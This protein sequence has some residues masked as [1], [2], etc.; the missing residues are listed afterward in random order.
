MLNVEEAVQLIKEHLPDW[1]VVESSIDGLSFGETI[2]DLQADRAYPPFNRVMMDGIAV[3][4]ADYE[5][6]L[7]EFRVQGVVAAGTPMVE[8]KGVGN[9]F[10]VMTGAPLPRGA[11]LVIQYEHLSIKDGLALLTTDIPRSYFENIHLQGSDCREGEVM[12][13]GHQRLNGP[14]WGI[15]AS[16]GYATVKIKR[17]PRVMIISTGDELV[18]VQEKPLEHQIRRSNAYALRASLK[19]FGYDDVQ[20]DHLQDEPNEIATHFKQA[21]EEF[22]LLI[23]SGGVSQGKFDY[24]PEVW[25]NHGVL[26]IFHGIAQRPGKPLFFGVDE[27]NK[28]AVVGLPG[29]PVSSLVCLHRYF[30]NHREMFAQLSEEIVFKK[31]LT[32]F[33]PVRLEFEPN[34][35]LKAHPLKMKNS[36]EF[37]ALAGSD[38]FIELPRHQQVFRAGEAF[39]FFPWG[40]L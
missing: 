28:T 15:A 17:S 20:L 18:P 12:L 29:N 24:L 14:H 38:G 1:G 5:K 34:G 13:Q 2:Q 32:S 35:L 37:T 36:G 22:D 10:E 27:K 8:L 25:K 39:K 6:G 30:L 40:Q 7:K 16:L 23:Y 19:A 3:R 33:V 21:T 4:F 31:D 9:C 11:D 26:K